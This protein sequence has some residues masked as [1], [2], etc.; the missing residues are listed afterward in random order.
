LASV[1]AAGGGGAAVSAGIVPETVVVS[2]PAFSF[3][4][5][6]VSTT[7]A[8][9][10]IVTLPFDPFINIVLLLPSPSQGQ[11]KNRS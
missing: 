4:A 2:V 3:L 5:H 10:S 9:A 7:A 11:E 6:A 8:M 1:Q